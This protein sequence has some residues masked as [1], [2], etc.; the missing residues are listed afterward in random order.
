MA[1]IILH[2][3]AEPLTMKF[4]LDSERMNGD[5]GI[6]QGRVV[7]VL[8]PIPNLKFSFKQG[9]FLIGDR[10]AVPA[11]V[12]ALTQAGFVVVNDS[13]IPAEITTG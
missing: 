5:H 3:T 8:V 4:E 11:I 7:S 13:E 12:R 2:W 1:T 9:R 10:A 6:D